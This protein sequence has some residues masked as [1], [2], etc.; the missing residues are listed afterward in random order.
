MGEKRNTYRLFV[1]E[2]GGR[3]PLGRLRSSWMYNIKTGLGDVGWCG[4]VW[5]GLVWL[6][7]GT[8]G[9]LL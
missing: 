4:L 1:G 6:R 7:I 2:P 9:E 3:M 8:S 5:T